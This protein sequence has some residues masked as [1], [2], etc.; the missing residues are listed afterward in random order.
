M[1]KTAYYAECVAMVAGALITG[2]LATF[3]GLLVSGA[4]Q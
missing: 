1:A 4:C 2:V 3:L